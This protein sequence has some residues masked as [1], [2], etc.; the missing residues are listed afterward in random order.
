MIRRWLDSLT[1]RLV[2]VLLLGLLAAQTAAVLLYL[3]ARDDAIPRYDLDDL[4]RRVTALADFAEPLGPAERVRLG[5]AMT[6]PLMAVSWQAERPTGGD[7]DWRTDLV[8]RHLGPASARALQ[9]RL[10]DRPLWHEPGR[11]Q[12]EHMRLAWP[13]ADGSWLV[14]TWPTLRG[15]FFEVEDLLPS[16]AVSTLAVFLLA[17]WATRRAVRPLRHLARAAD[18]LGRDVAAPPVDESGPGEIRTAARAFNRMQA[19]LQAFVQD[20]TRMLA[21][22]AHDLKTPITRLYLRAE[23]MDDADQRARLTADLADMEAMVKATLDFARQDHATETA[24]SLDLA[25]LARDLCADLA[26]TGLDVALI[27]AEPAPM[28]GRPLALRR[29]LTNLI[30]NAC[31]YGHRARV[32]VIPEAGRVRLVV[33]DN[34]PGIP[35]DRRDKVFAPFY[36]LEDSRSAET[37]GTGLGLAIV[38]SIVLGH[39]GTIA[40]INRPQGGLDAIVTL[41]AGA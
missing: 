17:A 5:E 13:L 23:L 37:G 41:P 3:F 38:R 2:L 19:R 15:R 18:R 7:A 11:P 21:A 36:R 22:I 32:T 16:I 31:R 4:H 1:G 35:E 14:F 33:A 26:A 27:E 9:V 25:A 40:L 8:V 10:V 12:V 28:V 20:R 29:V 24:E 34:G 6:V 39:G 30:T